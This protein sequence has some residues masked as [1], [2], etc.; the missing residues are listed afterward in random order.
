MLLW[1][2]SKQLLLKTALEM[3]VNISSKSPLAIF[4]TKHNLNYVK[5]NSVNTDDA[6][7]Y[8]ALWNSAMLQGDDMLKALEG[9]LTKKVARTLKSKRKSW[10]RCEL[11]FWGAA[12]GKFWGF[13]VFSIKIPY[14]W[15][16][17]TFSE[18]SKILFKKWAYMTS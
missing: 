5:N 4:G 13:R 10:K 15:A 2:E 3:A 17:M 8:I 6:L 9:K 14:V 7:S 11:T 16:Y 12:G 1:L 18:F